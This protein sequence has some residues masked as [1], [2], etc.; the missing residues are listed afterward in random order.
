MGCCMDFTPTS[1]IN[2]T[3]GLLFILMCY[4]EHPPYCISYGICLF[5]MLSDVCCDQLVNSLHLNDL[6]FVRLGELLRI[7]FGLSISDIW[8]VTNFQFP[9]IWNFSSFSD[10]FEKV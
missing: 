10:L 5:G 4:T 7:E 9:T 1:N 8:I 6:I 2:M 3:S